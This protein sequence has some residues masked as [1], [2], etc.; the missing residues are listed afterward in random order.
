MIE[1]CAG[2][3][4]LVRALLERRKVSFAPPSGLKPDEW[5]DKYRVVP[6]ETSAITGRWQTSQF[7][8]ARGAMRAL[9]EPGVR[10]ITICAS[11]QIMKTSVAETAIAYFIDTQPCPILVYQPT[12][13][14]AATF[15]DTKLDPMLKNSPRLAAKWGGKK[16]LELKRDDFTTYFK[17]FGGGYIEVMTAQA[18]ANLG[19]RSAKVVIFDEV[20]K[21]KVTKDGDVI[22]LGEERTKGFSG[23]ELSIRVS[24]PTIDGASPILAEYQKSDMRKPHIACP[25]CGA[26]HWLKWSN[27]HYKTAD[28]KAD[29]T[30][31]AY[32]C[33]SCGCAWSEAERV[34]AL[35]TAGAVEWRQ[36]RPFRCCDEHQE[37]D[38]ERRWDDEGRA[39]CKHCGERALP[40]AH[41]GFWAWEIYHPR[42]SLEDLVRS[43]LDC[44]GNAAKMQNFV[45]SKLAEAWKIQSDDYVVVDQEQ[46][47]SRAE[48]DWDAV[49]SDVLII[50]A[51]VDVQPRGQKS[52]GRLEVEVVGW[53]EGEE[54]WSLD[55]H[56]IEGDPDSAEV[57]AR[58]DELR[59][60]DY[61]T[62]DGRVLHI[63]ACC[64]DT[65]GHNTDAVMAYAGARRSQRVWPIKGA[66][67]TGGRR[68]PIWP[69]L[70]PKTVR[71]GA[72]LYVIAR[73]RRRTGLA[74]AS[75]APWPG[76]NSCTCLPAGT[77]VGSTRCSMKSASHSCRTADLPRHGDRAILA[78]ARRLWTAVFMQRRHWK[79]LRSSRHA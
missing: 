44:Q 38:R 59:Q 46:F 3:D 61:Q 77:P 2:R 26:W 21:F 57:W 68:H 76:L 16:K 62:A 39:L 64:I 52:P 43:W 72:K 15:V 32:Y 6:S 17:R 14:T 23:E 71:H 31:A 33:E 4:D 10:K 13:D 50:T 75:A 7:E 11:A 66:S 36:T 25:H 5:V 73:W 79:V 60:R 53:G 58:L 42:R 56:I 65:G 78:P 51:G 34:T 40:N 70:P 27:V 74:P 45:N 30:I 28:N 22:A 20:D 12:D 18:V 37:P 47:T 67:E 8:V 54:T 55:Y 29:P 49:P 24:T 35:T 69:A 63:Q 9:V 41:A 1:L 19:M 48:P